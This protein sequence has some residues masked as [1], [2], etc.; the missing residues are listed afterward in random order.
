[1]GQR[2]GAPALLPSVVA[3]QLHHLLTLC[4]GV[5]AS[6]VVVAELF[7]GRHLVFQGTLFVAV[8]DGGQTSGPQALLLQS[9]PLAV[10]CRVP[11]SGNG[12]HPV[13]QQPAL[14]DLQVFIGMWLFSTGV[15][16][17]DQV[18]RDLPL[19]KAHQH[20][21][22]VCSTAISHYRHTP[23]AIPNSLCLCLGAMT[24]S[25]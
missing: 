6:G 3:D 5:P 24:W 13:L 22:G 21:R 17:E 2:F 19:P 1:M 18:H 16:K 12:R 15:R 7:L 11:H 23:P 14:H 20:G 10:L 8:G 4:P 25:R 9:Q